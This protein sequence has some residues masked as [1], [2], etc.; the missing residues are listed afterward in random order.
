MQTTNAKQDFNSDD[1]IWVLLAELS[2]IDVL[3]DQ[4]RREE[5]VVRSLF[6]TLQELGMSPESMNNIARTLAEFAKEASVHTKQGK[7][8]FP[9]PIRILCQKKMIDDE[10]SVKTSQPYNIEQ[11]KKQNQIF[12]EIG[13]KRTGGWGFFIIE[14]GEDLRSDPSAVSKSYI[15]LYLYKEGD[16]YG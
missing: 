14:R 4:D 9:G 6:Q 13:T 11:G 12:S 3:P 15:D 2:F 7:L 8:D 10:G 1:P 16:R 5:P